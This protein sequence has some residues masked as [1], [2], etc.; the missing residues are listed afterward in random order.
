MKIA[1]NWIFSPPVEIPPELKSD[2]AAPDFLLECL[3][4]RGI[5]TSQAALAFLDFH[6]YTP[7][8]PD[9]LPDLP[10]AV[11]RIRK[12]VE[13]RETIGVWGDFDV[14]GQTATA[15]LVDTLRRIG[16]DVDFHIPVRGMESHGINLDPLKVFLTHSMKVLLTCDTGV[17]ANEAAT[18]LQSVGVDLIIT[19]HHQL[20]EILPSALAIINPQLLPTDNP[21]HDL[22]GVGVAYKL[23]EALLLS[24]GKD[25]TIVTLHDLVALGCVADLATL[26]GDT[27]Y[28]VQSGID[29]MRNSP[30]LFLAKMASKLELTLESFSEENI[31][32]DIAPR[33]N[34][35]G[36]LD[37]ANP[38]VDFLLSDDAEEIETILTHMEAL[39]ANR[40]LLVS[41]VFQGCLAQ[42]ETNP[43]LADRSILIL[44]HP[45]WPAGVVGIAAGRLAEWTYK[46]VILLSGAK[47]EILRGSVR[48]IPGID[49]TAALAQ[50]QDLLLTFGGH[51]MA[52]GLSLNAENLPEF[53]ARMHLTVAAMAEATH[54][55][56]ELPVETALNLDL[57]D[58]NLLADLDRL[59]PFGPGNPS[60]IFAAPG[61]TLQDTSVLGHNGD[62]RQ[63]IVEDERGDDYRILWW[64]G[65]D[66]PLPEGRFDLAYKARLNVYKG[67]PKVQYEWVDF[68]QSQEPTPVTLAK[69][70]KKYELLDFRQFSSHAPEIQAVIDLNQAF[71][72]QEGANA[73][74]ASRDRTS[75]EKSSTLV[76]QTV[77]PSSAD[78]LEAVSKIKPAKILFLGEIPPENDL[79]VFLREL[80]AFLK[81]A[82]QQGS[83]SF[84]IS[85]LAARFAATSEITHKALEW[86]AA[87]G[88]VTIEMDST[89]R[90]SI[91]PGGVPDP[92]NAADLQSVLKRNAGEISA[93]RRF[94][95][96][97]SLDSLIQ[98]YDKK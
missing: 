40:K 46:P 31:G 18:Y 61:L 6:K 35:V 12:A 67:T 70:A 52:A 92:A 76:I 87:K 59:A 23:A 56:A 25:D 3:V 44:S 73:A 13:N 5:T 34:A 39:N 33:M 10:K 98:N 63:A 43:G 54:V 42:L 95:L 2:L 60:P 19:D 8:S 16:A 53:R 11:E 65:A 28:L 75:F 88:L 7:T 49:I 94:Y 41:Q 47:E 84:S 96:S 50:N 85:D 66:L 15:V 20:P 78:L 57:V 51:P 45:D 26:R 90:V 9:T 93:F 80:G 38:M 24:Y 58:L 62:H 83:Q 82:A 37:D 71:F 77:P 86:Y 27:R 30:R 91:H 55:E 74:V 1:P 89:N 36:R 81:Q 4:R 64:Q 32:F 22:A 97:A 17:S 68:R 29:R 21:L 69:S 79:G 14:D 72:W 48:S